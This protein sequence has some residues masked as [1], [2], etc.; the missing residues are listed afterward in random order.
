MTPKATNLRRLNAYHL[1][2]NTSAIG[3]MTGPLSGL[4]P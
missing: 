1:I 4:V 2:L 3:L